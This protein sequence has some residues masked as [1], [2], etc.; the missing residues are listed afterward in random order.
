MD[1]M[2]VRGTRKLPKCKELGGGLKSFKKWWKGLQP[3]HGA[4][5]Q[6]SLGKGVQETLGCQSC[7]CNIQALVLLLS[8]SLS[9]AGTDES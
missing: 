2:C 9:Q 5:F 3:P 7:I 8:S 1:G 6:R 4:Y